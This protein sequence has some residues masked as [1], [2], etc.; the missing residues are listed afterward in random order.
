MAG[1]ERGG[2]RARRRGGIGGACDRAANDEDVGA[3][4]EGVA[5]RRDALLILDRRICGTD[6][7]NDGEEIALRRRLD[8]TDILGTADDAGEPGLARESRQ[9]RGM[10][11]PAAIGGKSSLM[12][13][14]IGKARQDGDGDEGE[15]P[16]TASAAARIMSL[17]PVACTLMIAGLGSSRISD[18]KPEATV[19][20]MSW[21]LRSRKI[22]RPSLATV[23]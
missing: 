19:L 18:R 23:S 21:S 22:G 6:A 20:G 1:L 8:G 10:I 2:N 13:I 11:A 4:I 14:G 9:R 16:S 7:G 12:D 3:V 5:R 17:P 15:R